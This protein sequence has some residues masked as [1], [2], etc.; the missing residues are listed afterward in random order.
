MESRHRES[1]HLL[2]HVLIFT[3]MLTYFMAPVISLVFVAICGSAEP[4]SAAQSP[5]PVKIIRVSFQTE[6]A[7]FH[8]G[9]GIYPVFPDE[10]SVSR[11]PEC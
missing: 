9:H 11:P 1:L 2:S 4:A 7:R 3:R 10:M 8:I 6:R 5:I